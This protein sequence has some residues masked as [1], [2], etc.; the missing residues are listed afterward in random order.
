MPSRL[1]VRTFRRRVLRPTEGV[2]LFHP[3]VLERLVRRDRG[4]GLSSLAIPS[5]GHYLMAR[6]VFLRSLEDENPDA[7]AVIEGLRSCAKTQLPKKVLKQPL[8]IM[9]AL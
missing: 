1:T 8:P 4:H 3:R 9:P 5:L 6:P 2:F 7:L